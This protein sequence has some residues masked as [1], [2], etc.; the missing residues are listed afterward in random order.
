MR[1][2]FHVNSY[3]Q[4]DNKIKYFHDHMNTL[5]GKYDGIIMLSLIPFMCVCVWGGGG[6]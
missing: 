4:Y 6:G 1:L 5:R 2:R 3:Y